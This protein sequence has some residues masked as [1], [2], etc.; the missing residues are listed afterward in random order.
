MKKNCNFVFFVFIQCIANIAEEL[1]ENFVFNDTESESFQYYSSKYSTINGVSCTNRSET[2]EQCNEFEIVRNATET[3]Y[4]NMTLKRDKHFYHISVNTEF[5]SVH[6]PTNVYDRGNEITFHIIISIHF[7]LTIKFALML[8]MFRSRSI[9][10]IDV[11]R[12]IRFSI[13]K[14]L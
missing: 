14:K 11:V 12:R 9:R 13:L 7:I 6:V 1:A 10:S 5:A 4:L 8:M 3:T 2:K